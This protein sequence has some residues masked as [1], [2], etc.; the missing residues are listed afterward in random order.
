MTSEVV[1]AVC[2]SMSG[3]ADLKLC[4]SARGMTPKAYI[5]EIIRQVEEELCLA[6]SPA[7]LTRKKKR[8]DS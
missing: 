8:F 4:A 7:S 5:E 3:D 2:L 1:I 6:C